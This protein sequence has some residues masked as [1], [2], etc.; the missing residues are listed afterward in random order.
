MYNLYTTYGPSLFGLLYRML[1]QQQVKAEELLVLTFVKVFEDIHSFDVKKRSLFTH[2]M[3]IA[4]NLAKEHRRHGR[5]SSSPQYDLNQSTMPIVD[6][7]SMQ[8]PFA[9]LFSGLSSEQEEIFCLVFLEGAT[10][11]EIA[12]KRSRPLEEVK[13]MIRAAMVKIRDL[14]HKKA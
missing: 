6:K 10:Y 9:D 7:D 3:C 4:R 14:L 12:S 5:S 2:M 11:A 8:E 1:G 13:T